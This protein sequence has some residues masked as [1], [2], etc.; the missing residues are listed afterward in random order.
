MHSGGVLGR[1][2]KVRALEPGCRMMTPR[3]TRIVLQVFDLKL[4]N[5]ACG[6]CGPRY[7]LLHGQCS[8]LRPA[9]YGMLSPVCGTGRPAGD[10]SHLT[11]MICI[12][13]A[14]PCAPH[15]SSLPS[16]CCPLRHPQTATEQG[17]HS[18]LQSLAGRLL[19]HR[20]HREQRL[21]RAITL[22]CVC[23]GL[24]SAAPGVDA[25]FVLTGGWRAP[26]RSGGQNG[27]PGNA[28]SGASVPRARY[29]SGAEL[30]TIDV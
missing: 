8:G 26:R 22:T 20:E 7:G 2:R 15:W 29:A 9:V 10:A 1:I 23:V 12:P 16:H 25:L 27:S 19:S 28:G 17:A 14:C 6:Q 13:A 11:L 4:L 3:P 18:R 21:R 5:G 30:Q 24:I